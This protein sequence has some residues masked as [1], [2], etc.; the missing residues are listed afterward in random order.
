M[1]IRQISAEVLDNFVLNSKKPHFMQTSAW[2][3]VCRKRNYIPHFLGF[4]EAE[5]LKGTALLLEKRVAVYSTYYCP[6]GFITDYGDR[7]VLRDMIAVLKDYVY[8]HNGL[9]FKIDPDIIIRKLDENAQVKETDDYNLSLIDFLKENGGRHRGFT[10]RFTESSAPRFTFRVDVSKDREAIFE[11]LHNTTRKI[12]KENNPYNVKIEKNTPDALDDFYKVMKETSFRKKLFVE[13][14]EYFRDFYEALK[15]RDEADIYTACI[16][17]KELKDIFSRRLLAVDE[18]KDNVLKRPEGPKRTNKLKDIEAKRNRIL[19]LK[20][21][22]DELNE[23]RIVL[24]SIITARFAD[25]VWTIHGG[26]SDRLQFLNANYELYYHI[27]LDSKD[28]GYS[29][30]DFY[31]SEG[32]VDRDSDIYGIYLFKLRFGGD[33]D[34]FIGEFDFITRPFMN[35]IIG[36]LLKIRRRIKYRQS[37]RGRQ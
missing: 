8:R 23:D 12:I 18:E 13:S 22:V 16:D 15:A 25:K 29:C 1:E 11:N 2:A 4:Y 9:Y 33:F 19:R 21:E 36:T 30:V 14:Y 10:T 26:N 35:S 37:L 5:E 31:G 3:D 6:R 7:R 20:N 28:N 32:K 17:V 27:L 34:E 24:S